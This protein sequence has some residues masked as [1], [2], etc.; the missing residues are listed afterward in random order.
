MHNYRIPAREALE[1]SRLVHR[2]DTETL[3][4]IEVVNAARR[5]L[6]AYAALVL[7]N[8]VRKIKPRDV[9]ISVLGVREGLLYEL[10]GKRERD[11]D[12]LVTAAAELNI[13]R[14]RSPRH[15]EE[16]IDWTDR[17][18]ASSGLDETPDEVRLRHTACL[19]GDIGWRAHPDYRGEQSM[20]LIAHGAFVSI[21]HPSRAYLALAV[22]FRHVGLNEEELSPRLRELATPHTLDRARVL[23]AAMRVAYILTAGHD[24]VLPHTPMRVKRGRLTLHLPGQ[25][26]G[27]ASDRLAGRLRQLARLVG[28]E[29]AFEF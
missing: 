5:P 27:L 19:L 26:A 1:F 22:F 4:K 12:P 6:L 20:N 16:L 13:L 21:D 3:S 10:L 15:G 25:F 2:V 14:S 18:I 11:S 29:P 7:E 23:G 9:V 8:L 17:F 28:R 24:G